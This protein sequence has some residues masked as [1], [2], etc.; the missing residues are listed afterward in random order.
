MVT[1]T[2]PT[3]WQR[4]T[5][6][7]FDAFVLRPENVER[8]FEYIGEEVL[9]VVSNELS[10]RI[11]AKFT[12]YL[13]EYL[14]DNDIGHVTGADGGYHVQS[15]RY[16]PD[17]AFISYDKLPQLRYDRGYIPVAPDLAVEVKSYTDSVSKMT[18]KT[19]NYLAAGTTVWLV[20]PEEQEVYIMQP[21]QAVQTLTL[22]DTLDGGGVLPGFS[23]PVAKFFP[24]QA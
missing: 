3:Q 12:R 6:A 10:S 19:A 8:H 22:N 20:D 16:I 23:V 9:E 4:M 24:K 13:D 7:E 15:E 5:V 21:G 11:G 17:A 18:I 2:T 1:Q 14:D